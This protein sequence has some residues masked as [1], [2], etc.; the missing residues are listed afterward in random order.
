MAAR[1]DGP[2]Y[3]FYDGPPF[4]TGTPHYGHILTSAIKD[5]VLAIDDAG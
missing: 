1:K 4:A 3:T 2:R 5:A